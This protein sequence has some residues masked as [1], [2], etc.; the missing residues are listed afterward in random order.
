MSTTAI[1]RV[2][3]WEALDSRGRPTVGCRVHL[4]GGGEGRAIV[5]S[6][7]STGGYEA[8]ERRDGGTRY[9]GLGVQQAVA[10]VNGALAAAVRGMDAED[11]DALDTAL[12]ACAGDG[13]LGALGANAVLSLSVASALAAADQAR[14]PLW[15]L[16]QGPGPVLLPMPMVNIV[17]GG[18]HAGGA[19]DVQDILVV[20]LAATSFAEAIEWVAR[21]RRATAELLDAAGGSSDLVA[22][23]G[24][25]AGALASNA[26][27]LEL[28]AR[29]VK[30]AGFVLGR[31]VHLA[32]DVAAN[33][34]HRSDG[35]YA[36]RLEEHRLSAAAWLE[37]L[38]TW[39]ARFCIASIE[40][41]LHEDDWD[42]W[43][44]AKAVLATT[45]Q[46]L[47]DDLFATNLSRLERGIATG[48]AN[49]V[50]IKPNQAGTLTRAG[51]V[52]RRAQDAG[53]ATVVSARSGDTED[54]WI[55]DLAVGWR[56]GQIKVGSTHRSERTAKWNRL[57]EIEA[58]AQSAGAASLARP[59][60]PERTP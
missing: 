2:L 36:L 51:R 47:G 14:Q 33:Q 28:V 26:A 4:A 31:E 38:A 34:L 53:Y 1:S 9:G 23:E 27:A 46:I 22:D 35:T 41:A 8:R 58:E 43:Q 49:A 50:L 42:A 40:D 45:P 20:P 25:L 17:S 29:G 7:A 48:A 15:R 55:A 32:L 44:Q 18:L 39:S 19:L 13:D 52:L 30:A 3:A 54:H 56:A 57:L 37:T 11:Q 6:G 24:G 12:E 10:A 60:W 59:G 16:L 21:I 5:P